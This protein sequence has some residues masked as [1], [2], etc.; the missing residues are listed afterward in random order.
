[1]RIQTVMLNH[2]VNSGFQQHQ[3][4]ARGGVYRVFALKL[5]TVSC[6]RIYFI[7]FVLGSFHDYEK[8]LMYKCI[9]WEILLFSNNNIIGLWLMSHHFRDKMASQ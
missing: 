2:L 4:T 1:M 8:I 7:E 5:N 3:V 6:M 9:G